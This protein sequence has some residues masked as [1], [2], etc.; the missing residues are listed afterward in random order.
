MGRFTAEDAVKSIHNS[1]CNP[2]L[3]SV[4][5]SASGIAPDKEMPE[6]LSDDGHS[7]YHLDCLNVLSLPA[8]RAL[9]HLELHRLPFLQAAKPTGLNGGE[10]HEHILPILT[11]VEAI[12]FSVVKSLYCSLFH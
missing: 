7:W 5:V 4:R 8:L 10:M 12:A 11:A 3:V 2:E 1:R 9:G 6:V